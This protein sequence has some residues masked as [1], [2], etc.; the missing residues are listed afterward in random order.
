MKPSIK[1]FVV[2]E[3]KP[4]DPTVVGNLFE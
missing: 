2:A 4:T 1:K 3:D